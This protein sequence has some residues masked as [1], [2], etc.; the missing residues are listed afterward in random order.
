LADARKNNGGRRNG[1][2]RKPKVKEQQLIEMLSPYDDAAIKK[3]S[4]AVKRGESWA[5]K[6]FFEYRFGK[7]KQQV[8]IT[9]AGEKI[10]PLYFGGNDD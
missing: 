10:K 5:I 8:D 4:A 7:P 1:A 6:L 2:G 3:L 9:S